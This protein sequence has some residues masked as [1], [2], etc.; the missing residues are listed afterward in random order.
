MEAR[1]G[2]LGA[3]ARQLTVGGRPYRLGELPARLGLGFEG[4]R[5]I[6][7]FELGPGT[8]V[9]RYYDPEEQRIV[10]VESDPEFHSRGEMR[11]DVAEW[12]GHEG[13]ATGGSRRG[14]LEWTSS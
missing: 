4:C 9:V 8:F 2:P 5:L 12:V 3:S 11:A 10:A 7:G 1:L 13:L 6:D 14:G